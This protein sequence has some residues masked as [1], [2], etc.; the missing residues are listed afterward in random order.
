[1]AGYSKIKVNHMIEQ[2]N[3]SNID[4][5]LT[6]LETIS[7][8][9]DG[10]SLAELA[11]ITHIPKTTTFRI[12]ES[13]KAREYV[14]YD[15]SNES[16]SLDIKSLELGIKGLMNVNLV[17][18]SIPYLKTLSSKTNET[19]FLG[20]YNQGHVIY[21][22]KSEG[23]MSIQTNARLGSRMPAY[24]TGIGKALLAYQ[25]LEEI[26]RVLNQKLERITEKTVTDRVQLYN[27]LADVR[28]NGYSFDNEEN[29]EGLTCVAKPIFNYT[30]SIIG[31]I[32][33]A[34]PTHRMCHKIDSIILELQNVCNTVSRRLG[35][36]GIL[37]S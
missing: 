11:K 32:S 34:G 23:T 5:A 10:I 28:L 22:Y 19:C 8:Y 37:S 20:V 1:M 29:E 33:V 30:N 36:I 24:C 27:I 6:I 25:P 9:A 3:S 31:A 16:Y 15:I 21:L 17:E 2:S 14:L 35:Y 13:L 18:V 4:K 12:L 26:D 7:N